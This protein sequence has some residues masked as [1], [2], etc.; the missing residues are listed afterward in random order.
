MG[1][2]SL[3]AGGEGALFKDCRRRAGEASAMRGAGDMS[4]GGQEGREGG[5]RGAAW[6]GTE[7]GRR[8]R[9]P[10]RLRAF[11]GPEAAEEK[12]MPS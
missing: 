2:M 12:Q 3:E 11:R 1:P 9:W 10:R 5:E 4:A 8:G 6:D 7:P